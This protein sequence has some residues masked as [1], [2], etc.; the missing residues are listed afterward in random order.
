MKVEAMTVAIEGY[1]S[2]EHREMLLILAGCATAA[3]FAV[4]LYLVARDGFSIGFGL[5]ALA[6]ALL[7]GAT[8]ASLLRRDSAH[9]AQ[10]VAA[11]G[12][13]NAQQEISAEAARIDVVIANYKY[14]RYTGLALGVLAL[15]GVASTR[16]G[17]VN[18]IGAGLLLLVSA[19]MVVD[20]Y[21]E[22][23][24][25]GY[26]HGYAAIADIEFGAASVRFMPRTRW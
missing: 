16:N 12:G 5:T 3:A 14:Y 1:F 21:S 2:G 7:L 10:L 26:A 11:L 18:G 25:L 9:E 23:R 13:A 8:S 20:H 19:Q 22:R 24:A 15:L 4:A 17:V 6:A